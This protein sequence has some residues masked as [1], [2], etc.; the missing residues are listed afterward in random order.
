MS[1]PDVRETLFG[2]MPL[3]EWRQAVTTPLELPWTL[4]QQARQSLQGNDRVAAEKAMRTVL[5][6]PALESRHYLQAWHFLRELGVTPPKEQTHNVLGVVVEVG[7]SQGFDLA[8]GYADLHARYFNFSGAA[9]VWERPDDRLDGAIRDL[10]ASAKPV[11]GKT[12]TWTGSRRPA[13]ANGNMRINVLT[14]GGL[15]F[16]E[17]PF[18]SLRKDPLAG[19]VVASAVRLM[20]ALIALTATKAGPER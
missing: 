19:P 11:G 10:L 18:I 4:F 8:A 6:I 17:G 1:M 13:P 9:V 7:V 3:S 5:E 15:H 16:G 14:P 20:Q 2:D 12:G